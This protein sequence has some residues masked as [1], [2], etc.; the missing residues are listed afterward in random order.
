MAE[1]Q[2]IYRGMQ[3][4]AETINDNLEKINSGLEKTSEYSPVT[5]S[6]WY[7]QKLGDNY[8]MWRKVFKITT[9]ISGTAGTSGLVQSDTLTIPNPPT[10]INIVSRFVT[11]GQ[12]P[13]SC[14]AVYFAGAN[15]FRLLSYASR[16]SGE[17]TIEAVLYGSKN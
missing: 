5:N 13:W 8:Y 11:A 10:S 14:W 3:N 2:K 15:A 16:D 1:I 6:G 4:G 9:A 12:A 7:E 17:V